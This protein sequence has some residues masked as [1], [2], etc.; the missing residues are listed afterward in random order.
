MRKN[1]VVFAL[2]PCLYKARYKKQAAQLQHGIAAQQAPLAAKPTQLAPYKVA[3][4]TQPGL[5][6]TDT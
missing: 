3:R 6:Q 2:K 4:T 5:R 1:P